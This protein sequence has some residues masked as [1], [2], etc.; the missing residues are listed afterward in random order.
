MSMNF[1]GGFESTGDEQLI[2]KTWPEADELLIHCVQYS[3]LGCINI[4]YQ[5]Q[6]MKLMEVKTLQLRRGTNIADC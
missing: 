5:F 6:S 1:E 4:L 3:K 2:F